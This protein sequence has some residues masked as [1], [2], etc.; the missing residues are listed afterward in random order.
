MPRTHVCAPTAALAVALLVL[1]APRALAVE[2]LD[3]CAPVVVR[4]DQRFYTFTPPCEPWWPDDEIARRADLVLDGFSLLVTDGHAAA[5]P[6]LRRAGTLVAHLPV[7]DVLRWSFQVGA[8]RSAMWDDEA[9]VVYERQARLVREAGALGELPIHLQ[10]LALETA[11]LG[12]LTGAERL[13]AGTLDRAG[14]LLVR[15][16]EPV[17]TKAG[18][19]LPFHV[20]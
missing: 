4:P 19:I 15:R 9:I 7:E 13:M 2:Q 1:G 17:A 11:W 10:A 12:D 14:T 20:T 18:K 5:M 6:V 16:Q 3:W 8:V